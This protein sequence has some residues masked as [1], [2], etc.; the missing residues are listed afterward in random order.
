MRRSEVVLVVQVGRFQKQR[1]ER[2]AE[3][4]GID[5]SALVRAVLQQYA[6]DVGTELLGFVGETDAV[7]QLERAPRVELVI[8]IARPLRRNARGRF[9]G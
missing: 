2:E 7:I 6:E 4:R 3:Q 9:R 1:L 8:P 5:L